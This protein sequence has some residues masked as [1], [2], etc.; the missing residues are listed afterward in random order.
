MAASSPPVPARTSRKILL[1]S[2][3]SFG[4][5]QALQLEFFA[6]QTRI[7]APQV[8]PRPWLGW[9]DL[10][11]PPIPAQSPRRPRAR[12]SADSDRPGPRAASTPSRVREIGFD[13]EMTPASDNSRLISSKRSSSFSSLRRIESFMAADYSGPGLNAESRSSVKSLVTVSA[14][15]KS[16]S[17][18][19]W[20]NACVGA[21]SS[22]FVRVLAR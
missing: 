22:R 1:S 14:S 16:A 9:R 8:P 11:P 5:Q 7:Q 19:A 21:C 3:G 2:C 20:R 17:S 13:L 10:H 15:A 18:E 4:H 6:Q 12:R